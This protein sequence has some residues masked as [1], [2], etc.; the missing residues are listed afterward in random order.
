MSELSLWIVL[1]LA[2]LTVMTVVTRCFFFITEKAWPMPQWARRG[3]Q[4]APIAAL[5]AVIAPEIVMTA[6][7]FDLSWRDA[8][9]YAAI[10]C[11]LF[12]FWKRDA[13]YALPG[14][15]AVGMAVYLPLHVGL[16]W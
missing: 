6:G 1:A 13:G 16:G 10:A 11:A 5:G 4:F 9:L 7:E 14:A 15:I 3:L 8:R 12:V 2:G